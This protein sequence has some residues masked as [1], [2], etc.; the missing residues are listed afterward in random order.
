[1]APKRRRNHGDDAVDSPTEFA[2]SRSE[3]DTR[4]S[5]S[6]FAK[7]IYLVAEQDDEQSAYSVIEIDAAATDADAAAAGDEP[8]RARTVAALQDT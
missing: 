6:E 1:M 2:K 8:L 7:P 3:G 4:G 5:S